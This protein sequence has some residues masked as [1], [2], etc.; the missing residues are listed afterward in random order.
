MI[1][2]CGTAEA[3]DHDRVR[4]VGALADTLA[5]CTACHAAWKQRVVDESTWNEITAMPGHAPA[6]HD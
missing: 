2:S 1:G 3:R 6:R 4:V 5:A